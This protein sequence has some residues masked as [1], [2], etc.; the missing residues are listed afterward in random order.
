MKKFSFVPRGQ[1]V[2][3]VIVAISIFVIIATSS[4]VVI[5]GSLKTARLSEEESRA[6][7]LAVEGLEAAKSI[8]NQAWVNLTIGQHGVSTGSGVWAFVGTSDVDPTS[9]YTRVI[10]ITAVGRDGSG[11][12]LSSGG[13][14]DSETKK[15]TSTVSWSFSPTRNNSVVL[16]LY[17]TNWQLGKSSATIPQF[18]SNFC[19]GLGYLGGQCRNGNAQ[20]IANGEIPE[21]AGNHLCVI[22]TEG[23][24][25]CCQL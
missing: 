20:C 22:Q 5:I 12:I 25:C 24:T 3:E 9:K 4:V 10:D 19:V 8:R 7:F 13:T 14:T 23:G 16:T 15:I 6:T 2:I 18:C 17:L 11:N 21:H 1:M